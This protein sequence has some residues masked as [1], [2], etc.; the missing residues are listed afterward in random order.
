VYLNGR[1]SGLRYPQVVETFYT[2]GSQ[3]GRAKA[4]KGIRAFVRDE[5]D[6]L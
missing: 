6:V 3:K 1:R 4:R 2:A 5:V